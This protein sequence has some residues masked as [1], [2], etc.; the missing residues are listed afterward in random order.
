MTPEEVQKTYPSICYGC[1]NAR[2]PASNENRD[3]GW[4]GCTQLLNSE[5]G[6]ISFLSLAEEAGEGWVDLRSPVFAEQGSGIITNF[7]LL[8]RKV[9]KCYRFENQDS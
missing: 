5:T 1:A 8:T 4:V 2:K 9:A 7:Q 3:N 6:D